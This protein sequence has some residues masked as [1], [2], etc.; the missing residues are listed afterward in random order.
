MIDIEQACS[1]ESH[2]IT[3]LMYIMRFQ[4]CRNAA[5]TYDHAVAFIAVVVS[6]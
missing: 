1:I 6:S 5:S 2:F 4:F 3:G